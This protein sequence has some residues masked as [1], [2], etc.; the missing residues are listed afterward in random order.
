VRALSHPR[1]K[2]LRRLASVGKSS[3]VALR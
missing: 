2:V 1:E 3:G